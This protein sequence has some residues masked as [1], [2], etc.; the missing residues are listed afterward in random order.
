M[1]PSVLVSVYFSEYLETWSFLYT[2]FF[3]MLA[4]T[5]C[6][7]PVVEEKAE[8][9]VRDGFLVVVLFWVVLGVLGALPF[10]LSESLNISIT[11][12]IFESMSG[13]TTTGAS[14]FVNIESLPKS[15]LFYRQFLQWLGGLGIIVMAV[16]I[17]P[18]L[19]IGGMQLYRAESLT[20]IKEKTLTPRITDTA[21]A[22]LNIYIALTI[23]C[24]IGYKLAGMTTYDALCH[25]FSTISI[26]GF[27][28]YS[29]NIAYFNSTSVELVA[30]VFMLLAAANFGLHFAAWRKKDLLPYREDS[31][32]KGYTAI[33]IILSVVSVTYLLAGEGLGNIETTVI[34]GVFQTVSIATTTGFTTTDYST[35]PS[36]LLMLLIISSFIGGCA[37]STG[38]GIKVVRFLLLI[39]QGLRELKRL[40]HPSSEVVI[41]LG[42]NVLNDKALESVWGFFAVYIAIFVV[43]FLLLIATD[44][45]YLS[46]FSAVAAT[47]NNLGPGLGAVSEGYSGVSDFGKWVLF[48]GMLF[49]RLEVFTLLIIFTKTFWK[50]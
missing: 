4:G 12:S 35:W 15:I 41:K 28:T 46:S 27:S 32:F 5:L 14:V 11:D 1:L 34:R 39:K 49:G 44:L 40:V 10:I 29:N 3:I 8:L 24:A 45:P 21:S 7:L 47:L 50:K 38:G 22:L 6:W 16:A 2:F 37:G 13:L 36:F 26:G 31:E 33:I 42:K 17:L 19:G 48:A 23:L 43:M 18:I 25:S 30:T 20:T 9:R